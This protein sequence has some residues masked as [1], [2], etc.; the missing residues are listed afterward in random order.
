MEKGSV[1]ECGG[2]YEKITPEGRREHWRVSRGS[3]PEAVKKGP[4]EVIGSEKKR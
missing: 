1:A 2:R 3:G 4:R